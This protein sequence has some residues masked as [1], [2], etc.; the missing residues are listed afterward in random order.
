MYIC[1]CGVDLILIPFRILASRTHT[2]T[3][4]FS[5]FVHVLNTSFGCLVYV[6]MLMFGFH[7]VL[8]V[9]HLTP[10]PH[11]IVWVFVRIHRLNSVRNSIS[12]MF[13]FFIW[14]WD[15]GLHHSSVGK[16]IK[17]QTNCMPIK[18]NICCCWHYISQNERIIS[19]STNLYTY[20]MAVYSTS[21]G[22]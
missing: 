19:S 8:C 3:H 7:C 4:N 15:F 18:A 16:T 20:M 6:S 11:L 14:F 10:S 22:I 13:L 9:F 5:D 21:R 17:I 2:H 1:V 12:G